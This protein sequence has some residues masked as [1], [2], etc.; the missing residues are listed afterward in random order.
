MGNDKEVINVRVPIF[1]QQTIKLYK[2]SKYIFNKL[3]D[4]EIKRLNDKV[5]HLGILHE[6]GDVPKFSRWNHI[7]TMLI[8]IEKLSELYKSSEDIS[9]LQS[10]DISFKSEVKLLNNSKFSSVEDLLKCWA[11]IYSVGHFVGTFTTEHA[12]LK[13]IIKQNGGHAFIEELRTNLSNYIDDEEMV[14]DIVEEFRRII[15]NEEDVFKFFK[16]FTT[17]KVLNL[18]NSGNDM[19]K[20]VVELAV[21]NLLGDEYLFKFRNLDQRKKLENI[22]ELFKIVRQVSYL[23]LDGY[24]S[25]NFVNV[26]PHW[27]ILNVD[28]MFRDIPYQDLMNNLN[29]FYTKTVYQSP[30]NMCYHHKIVQKIEAEVFKKYGE[31][32]SELIDYIVNNHLDKEI[33]KTIEDST[34]SITERPKHFARIISSELPKPVTLENNLFGD[35]DGGIIK[36]VSAN[37]YEIDIYFEPKCIDDIFKICR[38][39][40]ELFSNT[41]E[42]VDVKILIKGFEEVGEKLVISTLNVFKTSDEGVNYKCSKRK[43]GHTSIVFSQ[44]TKKEVIEYI[45][46]T[47]KDISNRVTKGDKTELSESISLIEKIVNNEEGGQ[48][49]YVYV[50]E[51]EA[52]SSEK[53]VIAEC[54]FM[55]VKYN[56]ATSD[57]TLYVAEIKSSG[58][59]DKNQLERNLKYFLLSTSDERTQIIDKELSKFSVGTKTSAETVTNKIKLFSKFINVGKT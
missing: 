32:W 58:D 28:V 1:G 5:M 46:N 10:L 50:P 9:L 52:L 19:D 15:I 17:L 48:V 24:F 29:I 41:K 18:F 6:I 33:L 47:I 21:F 2:M 37:H 34:D 12:L 11:I 59:F 23:I 36:N 53:K 25:Q 54:D 13:Y 44:K 56:L 16:I 3:R 8:L 14:N 43:L 39:V 45:Q 55:L 26:N 27:L 49:I 42:K 35:L 38:V 57:V 7:T 40:F 4:N 51:I 20:S 22:R 31:R 30:E